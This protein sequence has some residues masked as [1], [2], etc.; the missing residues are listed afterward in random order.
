MKAR[1]LPPQAELL[2]VF[3]YDP[4]VPSCLVWRVRP[5]YGIPAGTM[6]GRLN[7]K[8]RWR[9]KYGYKSW[10]VARI[11]WRMTYG[12]EPPNV[13]HRNWDKSD[14][15]IDNLRAA[16]YRQNAA[17][18]PAQR[19]HLPKGVVLR[20]SGRYR[21]RIR[22]LSI[23]TNLGTFDTV[24]Q[25]QAAYARAARKAF[26]HYAR[27]RRLPVEGADL[28]V[29]KRGSSVP[30]YRPALRLRPPR[31]VAKRTDEIVAGIMG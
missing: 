24:E 28:F 10:Y 17:N 29:L 14:N 8:G 30:A 25:A 9:V 19:E 2:H 13:D 1:P 31:G 27:R 18:R 3:C 4:K 15:R 21:A 22:N 16:T 23:L 11:I 6:A 20:N 12:T 26:G 5:R 7:E